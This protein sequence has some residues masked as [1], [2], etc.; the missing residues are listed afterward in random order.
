MLCINM[1]GFVCFRLSGGTQA[2]DVAFDLSTATLKQVIELL[3]ED[4]SLAEVGVI[5]MQVRNLVPSII[6]HT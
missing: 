3:T 2:A 5:K 4:Q 6:V 1:S